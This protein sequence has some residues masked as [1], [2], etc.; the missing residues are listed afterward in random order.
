MEF[1]GLV[2]L[3]SGVLELGGVGKNWHV[4]FRDFRQKIRGVRFCSE[5][6]TTHVGL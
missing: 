1:F 6:D 4:D 5:V 2:T 3:S